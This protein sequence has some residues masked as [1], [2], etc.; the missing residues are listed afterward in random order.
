[1][2]QDK[3]D[4]LGDIRIKTSRVWPGELAQWLSALL[5]VVKD[6]GLIPS[7]HKEAYCLLGHQAHLWCT[8]AVT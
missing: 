5:V 4:H 6:L 1:M 8:D 2:S 7:N 3:T